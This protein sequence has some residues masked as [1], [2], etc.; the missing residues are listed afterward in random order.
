[1]ALEETVVVVVDVRVK[2]AD[3]IVDFTSNMASVVSAFSCY[4]L[5]H[6]QPLLP[7]IFLLTAHK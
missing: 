5:L 4:S 3:G 7:F 2:L 1:M 6:Y